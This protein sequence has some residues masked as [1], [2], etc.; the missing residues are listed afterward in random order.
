MWGF[1]ALF[2]LCYLCYLS[3]SCVS[4]RL[5]VHRYFLP[6]DRFSFYYDSQNFFS[7]NWTYSFTKLIIM[8]VHATLTTM[9]S[10]LT[11]R[12]VE[13]WTGT[14]QIRSILLRM[15]QISKNMLRHVL[16]R[17]LEWN[18]PWVVRPLLCSSRSSSLLDCRWPFCVLFIYQRV[19]IVLHS[20]SS[21][22]V[23]GGQKLKSLS[24]PH[25]SV[26]TLSLSHLQK[27]SLKMYS[28]CSLRA[29]Q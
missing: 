21:S 4:G 17:L 3:H 7:S 16:C 28:V 11:E 13:W 14:Y 8:S 23:R 20:C 1:S 29:I 5:H 24:H 12:N 26:W 25:N 10:H 2:G 15:R 27:Q 22:I 18:L 9:L 19:L 6:C